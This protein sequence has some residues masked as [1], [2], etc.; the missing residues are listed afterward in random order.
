M[1]KRQIIGSVIII[2]ILSFICMY[3]YDN[4]KIEAKTVL[5]PESVNN[6]G[7]REYYKD[8][9]NGY[10][11]YNIDGMEVDFTDRD[12]EL[13]KALEARQISIEEIL[14]LLTQ[15]YSIENATLYQNEDISVLECKL[16]NGKYNYLFGG[17]SMEY[18]E[19]M[20]SDKPYLCKFDKIYYVVDISPSKVSD[21]MYITLRSDYD[22]E[23]STIEVSKDISIKLLENNYY[24]FTFASSNKFIDG[25]I[26]EIFDNN[27]ILDIKEVD[28][29]VINSSFCN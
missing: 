16:D 1:P 21:D 22:T 9:N 24:S 11:L 10:Y 27:M 2:I 25:S 7:I 6:L 29:S 15:K 19:G 5:I 14:E 23:T 12:L 17:S 8:K 18:K 20:C 13:N 26:K 3:I 28:S 4:Y